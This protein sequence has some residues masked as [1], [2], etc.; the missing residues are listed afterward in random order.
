MVILVKV[1]FVAYYVMRSV[2]D[3][4]PDFKSIN[5]SAENLQCIKVCTTTTTLYI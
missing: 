3:G 1:T 4:L 5:S 2:V